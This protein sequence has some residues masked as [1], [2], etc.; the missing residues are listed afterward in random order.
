MKHIAALRCLGAAT[1]IAMAWPAHGYFDYYLSSTIVG[2][3]GKKQTETLR[4][5]LRKKLSE[6]DDGARVPF[7]LPREARGKATEG[8]FTPVTTRTENGQR[9]RKIRSELR[10]AGKSERW[11][12]W[13]CQQAS[14]EWKKTMLKD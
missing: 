9:C 14:G 3:L 2:T 13:Y 7:T 12:G 6:S 8:T 5:I 11:E 4:G 1:L 10:Q